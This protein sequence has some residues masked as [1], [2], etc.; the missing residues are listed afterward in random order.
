MSIGRR[1]G[2]GR[3]AGLTVWTTAGPRILARDDVW[4]ALGLLVALAAAWRVVAT[5]GHIIHGD[6]ASPYITEFWIRPY[7]SAWDTSLGSN[8][9]SII[10]TYT[11]LPW[12]LAIQ[13]FGLSA[14]AAAKFHWLSWHLLAFPAGYFGGRLLIGPEIRASHPVA[15]RLGLALA[16]L[17][18]ALNPW[19][20]AR[21]EQLG[22]HVSAVMLP[23]FFGFVVTATLARGSRA[24]AQRALAAAATLG[25][26]LST[27]PHYLA[28][29]FALGL[30][31]FA[32]AAATTRGSRRAILTPAAVFV[33][34]FALFAGFILVPYV[35]AVLAGS[36]TGPEY[37]H[38]DWRL[39]QH[40]P[41]SS[42]GNVLTLTGQDSGGWGLRP[43][44]AGELPGWRM[45]ALVPPALLALACWRLAGRRQVLGYAA[46]VGGAMALL[47]IA[48][49][50]EV[51]RQAYAL[52]ATDIPLGWTLRD[53]Y[54]LTGALA[55]A[56]L[57]GIAAGPVVF[58]RLAPRRL[59][60]LG[61]I[62]TAALVLALTV[63]MLPGVASTILSEKAFFVPERFPA[64]FFTTMAEI[65]RRNA[66]TASRTLLPLWQYRDPEWSSHNSVMH[67]IELFGITTPFVSGT[68]SVGRRLRGI[69]AD[70]APNA[71]DELR[72]HGVA[73]VLVPTD[74]ADGRRLVQRLRQIAGLEVDF[75]RDYYEVFRTVEPPYPWVYEA[76]PVELAWR[77]EGANRLVIDVPPAGER[78]REILTQEFWDSLWTA[79]LPRH[80]ATVERSARGLLSVRL[81][82]GASGTLVLEYG[83]QRA[84]IAGHA[85]T[86]AGLAAWAAWTLWPRRPWRSGLRP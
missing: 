45:A 26:A 35:V 46:I 60:G 3:T 6:L 23:L 63:Y 48:A 75:A 52:V 10:R 12:G 40:W 76:G 34:G 36:P 44:I 53:P 67:A 29:G 17:F 54:K 30:G 77:R 42:V 21:W 14:E 33:G 13:A 37:L 18:W 5:P 59:P 4:V 11:Y 22:V 82:P 47:Q 38:S 25:L 8:L 19:T 16:G 68:T 56:Y 15:V 69:V 66:D 41:L 83:L 49:N 43:A 72:A 70:A 64:S 86:W 73:R 39:S 28:I 24:R 9:I 80:N 78:A 58:A 50:A 51:T 81:E 7:T 62:Q 20:L 79:E 55:L 65:D 1:L 71:A 2:L 31:W 84:L 32:Y 85:T 27:S 74:S 57:P 61:V